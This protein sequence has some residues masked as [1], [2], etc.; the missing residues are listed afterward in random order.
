MVREHHVVI[1]SYALLADDFARWDLYEITD[2]GR[3]A[4]SLKAV[5]EMVLFLRP[6]GLMKHSP[7]PATLF[8]NSNVGLGDARRYFSHLSNVKKIVPLEETDHI[9]EQMQ[10]AEAK[11]QIAI[12]R[13]N[14][15]VRMIGD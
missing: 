7:E 14:V 13:F 3:S 12:D 5:R 1:G 9:I 10:D 4:A 2:T 6:V 11:I 15:F 8:K